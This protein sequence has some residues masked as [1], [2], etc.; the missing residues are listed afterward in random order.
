MRIDAAFDTED[1]PQGLRVLRASI[2]S[3]LDT[4]NE[5]SEEGKSKEVQPAIPRTTPKPNPWGAGE[6]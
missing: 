4:Q 2:V 1:L 5:A 6:S 3:H